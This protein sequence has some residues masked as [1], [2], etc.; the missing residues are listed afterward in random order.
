MNKE[1][2]NGL[3]KLER[4]AV[5]MRDDGVEPESMDAQQL[6][7]YLKD[8]KVDMTDPAKRVALSLK[9]AKA[10]QRLERARARRLQ[11]IEKA[12]TVA[13]SGA[14]AVTA[15]RVKVQ[16]MIEK[17]KQRDPEQA[18]VYAREFEKATPE[19]YATFVEDLLLLEM[20]SQ[21]DGP[22]NQ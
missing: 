15:I 22:G 12:K 18:L 19:D 13:S 16:G 4:L 5:L 14:E 7:Q 1:D 21:E 3:T 9:R 8:A 17:L 10:K 20:E 11:A 2:S 6:A